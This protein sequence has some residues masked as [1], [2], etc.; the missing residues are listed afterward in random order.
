MKYLFQKY[1]NDENGTTAV[2][3]ALISFAFLTI[4]F[5]IIEMGRLFMVYN[6]FQYAVEE[7]ARFAL[8]NEDVTTN[9]LTTRILDEME[10]F[11]ADREDITVGED[12]FETSASGVNFVNVTGTYSYQT[13]VPFLP[14]SWNTF[15]MTAQT[16][17]PRP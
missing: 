9:D 4:L 11:F 12:M 6:T 16:R 13:L 15:E 10:L 5:S 7:A 8:V 3:F 2:E 1:K 14:E 17:L